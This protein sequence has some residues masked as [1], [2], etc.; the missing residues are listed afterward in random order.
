[1]FYNC[2]YFAKH[3]SHKIETNIEE[4]PQYEK[5]LS[6]PVVDIDP[7]FFVYET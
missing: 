2:Y 7:V 6:V 4:T 3:S 1:M 5:L